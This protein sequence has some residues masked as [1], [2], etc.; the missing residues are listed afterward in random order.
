MSKQ[1]AT[2]EC[3]TH[4]IAIIDEMRTSK[5][6]QKA[7]IWGQ[8]LMSTSHYILITNKVLFLGASSRVFSQEIVSIWISRMS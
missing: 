3:V 7:P 6:H 1:S 5:K 8:F 2:K 4:I